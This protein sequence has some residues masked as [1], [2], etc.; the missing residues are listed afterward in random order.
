M[1]KCCNENQNEASGIV[2]M[3]WGNGD[4]YSSLSLS[5]DMK[6]MRRKVLDRKEVQSWVKVFLFL[7]D[8]K[9]VYF[10]FILCIF[11]K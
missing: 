4:A 2:D 3:K 9:Y 5:L 11:Y 10:Q 6:Q 1:M 8:I 7:F